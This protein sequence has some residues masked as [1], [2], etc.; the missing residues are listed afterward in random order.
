MKPQE[1][2]R[3]AVVVAR[4]LPMVAAP[5]AIEGR[6]AGASSATAPSAAASLRFHAARLMLFP[7]S[8]QAQ[9]N[10]DGGLLSIAF[11]AHRR[12]PEE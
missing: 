10:P 8:R 1:P 4:L 11:L 3:S 5:D 7:F 12:T 2:F 6:A 9:A